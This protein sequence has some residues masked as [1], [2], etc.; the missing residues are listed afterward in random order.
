MNSSSFES[1]FRKNIFLDFLS[2]DN[3]LLFGT[4][5]N[6]KEYTHQKY[7]EEGLNVAV[8]LCGERCLL[9]PSFVTQC[10]IVRA[11]LQ[12]KREFQN[13]S[14][15]VLPLRE[16]NL[17]DFFDKKI[18]EYSSV[19]GVYKGLFETEGQQFVQQNSHLVWK[20]FSEMGNTIANN[21]D[22]GP[23]ESEVWKPIKVN[24]SHF[25]I[26]KIR[27]IPKIL[28][29]EGMSVT[30]PA[31][32]KYVGPAAKEYSFF[33]D[34]AIQHEYT[35]TYLDEYQAI[36]ISRL[37]SSIK[38]T[39]LCFPDNDL[40]YDYEGLQ[41]ALWPL[42]LWEIVINLKAIDIINL[43]WNLGYFEFIS[44]FVNACKISDSRFTL[45]HFFIL[46][47]KELNSHFQRNSPQ[48][49][50]IYKSVING[51]NLSIEDIEFIGSI[52]F[53]AAIL[54]A[55]LLG[56]KTE[57]QTHSKQ[58]TT[59]LNIKE[60][61]M[62]K[63]FIVHGQ[64]HNVRNDINLFLIG[65][66]LD[67]VV[68]AAGAHAGRTLPEKFEEMAKECDFAVFLLTADD[69]LQDINSKKKLKRAR[70]NV[71]LEIG[72]FWGSMGRKGNVAFLVEDDPLMELPSDIQGLAWIPITSDLGET[73]L[74]LQEELRHSG[75][76]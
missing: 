51:A 2:P 49:S 72:Y 61:T 13:H 18:R 22:A 39:N 53:Q 40:S 29:E 5:S 36:T 57:K 34:Q 3:R 31:F 70:Q 4:Y 25:E 1:P 15:I 28:K 65:L 45:K 10:N 26:E 8:F 21:W 43:R 60:K 68:M 50:R 55:S 23:D 56:I 73:K 7:L 11:V 38:Q 42:G 52:L 75:V 12:N 16:K 37:P 27:N 44:A 33:I 59:W 47:E 58:F 62:K 66:G 48:L 17:S 14:L 20:R 41:S 46:I 24:L 67:T 76:I 69:E 64:N 30:W 54:S 19:K 32:E 71:V 35:K 9:P 6:L 63:V 74:K